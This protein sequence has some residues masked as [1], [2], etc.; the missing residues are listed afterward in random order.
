VTGAERQRHF[1]LRRQRGPL[2]EGHPRTWRTLLINVAAEII[3]ST[4]RILVR[5]SSS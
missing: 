2:G 5:L 4:R 1:R 3:V